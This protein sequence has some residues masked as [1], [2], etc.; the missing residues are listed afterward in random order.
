MLH[1]CCFLFV[2]LLLLW[3]EIYADKREV[4]PL[5]TSNAEFPSCRTHALL[6]TKDV[7]K[8]STLKYLF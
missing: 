4:N 3:L 2:L 6:Y 7:K 1:I 8:V 5:H